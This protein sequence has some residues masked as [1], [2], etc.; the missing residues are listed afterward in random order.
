MQVYVDDPVLTLRGTRA[1]CGKQVA[2]AVLDF[3]FMGGSMGEVVGEKITRTVELATENNCPMIIYSASGGVYGSLRRIC[4][5]Y[6][7]SC[8]VPHSKT[9]VMSA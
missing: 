8:R 1:A 4:S 5:K 7:A 2:M 9:L 6:L 3:T